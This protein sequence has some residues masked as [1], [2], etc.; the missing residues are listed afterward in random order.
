MAASLMNAF[1]ISVAKRF[2][3]DHRTFFPLVS[4]VHVLNTEF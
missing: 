2:T 1:I 3:H 4:L